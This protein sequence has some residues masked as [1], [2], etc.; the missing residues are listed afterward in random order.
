MCTCFSRLALSKHA[1]WCSLE[2]YSEIFLF[3]I[4]KKQ[5]IH[6]REKLIAWSCSLSLTHFYRLK[7][8]MNCC[9]TWE[10]KKKK[11]K[12]NP[13]KKQSNGD[14]S[15]SYGPNFP[16]WQ[17]CIIIEK[18]VVLYRMLSSFSSPKIAFVFFIFH[19]HYCLSS[20][21]GREKED[22]LSISIR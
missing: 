14:D 3:I 11:K 6:Q 15:T 22:L 13:E 19:S 16:S 4:L 5:D 2:E 8:V 1:K 18:D 9:R 21:V 10:E 17:Q 12:K 7:K 20:L